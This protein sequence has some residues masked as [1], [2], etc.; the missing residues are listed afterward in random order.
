MNRY[1]T[2]QTVA[3]MNP[4]Y[5]GSSVIPHPT[6]ENG[7]YNSYKENIQLTTNSCV[8]GI[9]TQLETPCSLVLDKRR[10]IVAI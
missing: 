2:I 9:T 4:M 3:T 5:T 10:C 8:G 6:L 7:Q 1:I